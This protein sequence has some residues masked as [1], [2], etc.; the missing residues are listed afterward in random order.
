MQFIK[1]T[2]NKLSLSIH[3]GLNCLHSTTNVKDNMANLT[4]CISRSQN[5]TYA[6]LDQSLALNIFFW[7]FQVQWS[8]CEFV[9]PKTQSQRRP[10]WMIFNPGLNSSTKSDAWKS[11]FL[12]LYSCKFNEGNSLNILSETTEQLY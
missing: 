4:D 6:I 3:S 9:I 1:V 2:L 10:K 5:D 12:N 11:L 7:N 8:S